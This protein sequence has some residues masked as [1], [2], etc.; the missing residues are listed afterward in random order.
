MFTK[1]CF[2]KDFTLK[3][4]TWCTVRH[5]WWFMII[6]QHYQHLFHIFPQDKPDTGWTRPASTRWNRRAP[7]WCQPSTWRR[8]HLPARW[9]KRVWFG[10]F[11]C[12]ILVYRKGPA[13]S[14]NVS[15]TLQVTDRFFSEPFQRTEKI[16]HWNASCNE[17]N[18]AISSK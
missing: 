16:E 18:S 9:S 3:E 5:V 14:L 8:D 17:L 7:V 11:W 13:N 1:T 2:G 6:H 4:I 10:S 15:K 12:L